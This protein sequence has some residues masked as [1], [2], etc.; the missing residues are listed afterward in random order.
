MATFHL[1]NNAAI[2]AKEDFGVALA[3]DKL[4]EIDDKSDSCFRPI[5]P[6][7]QT[8]MYVIWKEYQI[9]IPAAQ[10]MLKQLNNIL[11]PES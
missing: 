8:K 3:F 10:L 6:V 9:F 5:A 7:L 11:V 4:I 2:F 1:T